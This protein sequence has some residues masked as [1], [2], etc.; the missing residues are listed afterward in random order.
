MHRAPNSIAG[1]L[2]SL[3]RIVVLPQ[4]RSVMSGR[5]VCPAV[6]QCA[7]PALASR[8]PGRPPMV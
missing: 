2:V 3:S 8:R 6:V 4:P 7:V 1:Q 5:I